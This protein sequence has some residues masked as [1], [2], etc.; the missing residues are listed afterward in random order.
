MNM[1]EIHVPHFYCME[2]SEDE[3]TMDIEI[4][5]REDYFLLNKTLITHWKKP[6]DN[7]MISDE[8]KVEIL[9]N[10]YEYLLM[11]TVPSH[12]RLEI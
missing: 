9:K 2:Y 1:Y 12:I 8:K 11:K 4:D 6:Y 7:E 5:F 3:H 10:I